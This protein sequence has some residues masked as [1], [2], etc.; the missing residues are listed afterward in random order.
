MAE[1]FEVSTPILNGPF[2]PPQE[3][4]K[5]EPDQLAVRMPGR[6]KAGYYF[7]P[8]TAQAGEDTERG[9]GEWR[10]LELV[11][12]IRARMAKW[13]AD[14]R[15]GVTR[16]TTEL[17]DYWRRDGRERRLFFA[18]LEAAETIIFLKEARV[19]YLQGIVVPS[20]EPSEERKAEGF[21]AFQRY[22]GKMATG[23]GKS[24]VMAMLAAWSIPK[25]GREP[26][27]CSIF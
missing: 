19:D 3:H 11:N 16:T 22:C 17:I 9:I 27:R 7:R 8:P 4:W 6:R 25:Q 15:P 26:G 24:T 12:R 21:A 5:I 10:E 23:S 20:D 14:T 13:Q 2:D 18:Q 1:S